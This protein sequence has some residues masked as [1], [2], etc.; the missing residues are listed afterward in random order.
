MPPVSLSATD[1]TWADSTI[2][3]SEADLPIGVPSG[4]SPIVGL[5]YAND[6][7]LRMERA[8][9]D[10][11]PGVPDVYDAAGRCVA[12]AEWPRAIDMCN[13]H[14]FI[15][16]RAVTTVATVATDVERVVRPRFR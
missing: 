7:R 15:T 13:G 2:S 9:A 10:G 4:K 16:G 5:T 8:V 11:R 14:S 1:W 12:V 6:G 3:E